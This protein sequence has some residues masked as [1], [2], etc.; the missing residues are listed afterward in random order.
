MIHHVFLVMENDEDP[1]PVTEPPERMLR[2]EVIAGVAVLSVHAV[3]PVE[4]EPMPAGISAAVSATSL[5][6]AL[7]VMLA[8]Q[9]DGVPQAWRRP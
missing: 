9:E 2:V 4:G 6:R 7:N 3:D 5:V 8:D 1:Q